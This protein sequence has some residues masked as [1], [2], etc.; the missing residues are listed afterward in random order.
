MS[1]ARFWR[2]TPRRYNLGGSKCTMCGTV[3]FPPR[4]V[5]PTCAHHRES[6]GKMVPFQLS[7]DGEVFSFTIVHEP[8]EGFE[9]QVPYI[10]A[11]VRTVE[12]PILTGQVVDLLPDEVRIGLKVRATFRKLREE[13]K[14]GVIHYGYKFAPADDLP[15]LPPGGPRAAAEASTR[16]E[17]DRAPA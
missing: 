4:S 5:C 2:E 9:M 1:I 7:G 12:G 10:L 16:A 6:I 15:S 3:Y 13:G 8:A 17:G 14:A 11:L